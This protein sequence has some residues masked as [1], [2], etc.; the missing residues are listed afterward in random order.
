MASSYKHVVAFCAGLLGWALSLF[1]APELFEGDAGFLWVH[2]GITVLSA[3]SCGYLFAFSFGRAGLVGWV[4]SALG[5]V[6]AT[7]FG[8]VIAGSISFPLFGTFTAPIIV[9]RILSTSNFALAV[10]VIGGIGI[11][12]LATRVRQQPFV[13]PA[14]E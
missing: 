7:A 6:F 9:F 5:W 2:I 4:S 1:Y 10:W 13:E 8:A 11:H 12:L 3:S 14:K